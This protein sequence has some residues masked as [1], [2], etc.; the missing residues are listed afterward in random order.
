MGKI[1][2]KP[3]LYTNLFLQQLWASFW[4]L[5]CPNLKKWS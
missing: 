1:N 4:T 5:R 2:K 3:I